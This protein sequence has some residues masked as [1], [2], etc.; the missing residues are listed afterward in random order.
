MLVIIGTIRLPAERLDEARPAMQR[1]ISGSRTEPGCIDYSYAQDVLDAGLIHVTEVWSDRA[2]LDAHFRS[3]HIA[4]W[5]ASWA[6]L[7]IGERNL[8][9]YEAGEPKPT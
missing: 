4:D 3:P 2:A 6:A 9:L 8:M 7:G 5:R 1:M